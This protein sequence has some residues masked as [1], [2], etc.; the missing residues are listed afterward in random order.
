MI[1]AVLAG[2]LRVV[3]AV[4]TESVFDVFE[5]AVAVREVPDTT[6]RTAAMAADACVL[7][8]V[9]TVAANDLRTRRKCATVVVV[10]VQ[11]WHDVDEQVSQTS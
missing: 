1:P 8:M 3:L 9:V 4:A 11:V 10:P 6:A 2:E 7:V 5:K